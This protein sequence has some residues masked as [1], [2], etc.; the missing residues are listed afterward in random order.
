MKTFKKKKKKKEA[1]QVLVSRNKKYGCLGKPFCKFY[2]NKL[3]IFNEKIKINVTPSVLSPRLPV[4]FFFCAEFFFFFLHFERNE[5][6]K[7]NIYVHIE[8]YY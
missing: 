1:N 8:N 3:F 5:K 6:F 2:I 4:Y 7:V